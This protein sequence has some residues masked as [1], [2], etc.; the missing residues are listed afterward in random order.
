MSHRLLLA[1]LMGLALLATPA[2]RAA[3]VS[4]TVSFS[5]ENAGPIAP[6][7]GSFD[8]TFDTSADI[9]DS[10]VGLS[11]VVLP[12]A[13]SS[14]VPAFFYSPFFFGLDEFFAL[15]GS[16]GGVLGGAIG[17]ND[18]SLIF[19]GISSGNPAFFDLTYT[20]EQ[21]AFVFSRTGTVTFTPHQVEVPA[22]A[23]VALFGAGL[24]GLTALR[25]RAG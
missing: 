21:G 22:P 4:G 15:G 6:F 25:R 16:D 19:S 24:L 7:A 17:V 20:T 2:A 11:N 9:T 12:F 10:T 3:T 18:F 8:I 23:A 14:G 13:L 1:S 5:V